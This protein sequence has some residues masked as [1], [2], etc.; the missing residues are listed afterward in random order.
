MIW[1]PARGSA[2]TGSPFR[3]YSDGLLVEPLVPA[4]DP[5]TGA[6]SLRLKLRWIPSVLRWSALTAMALGALG[7]RIERLPSTRIVKGL[8]IVLIVD[9]SRSMLAQ[10]F[11]PNRLGAARRLA[12]TLVLRRVNDR[13]GFITFAGDV[14]LECPVTADRGTLLSTI[15]DVSTSDRSDGTAL[16]EAIASGVSRLMA[17]PTDG[18]VIVVLTD[19][20]S[21]AGGLT[22]EQ[23]AAL[24]A[25]YNV[26][27]Y[28]VGIGASGQV[29]YPTEFGILF[30]ALDLDE[31]VLRNVATTT[32]GQFLRAADS[33]AL[34]TAFG[35]LD[36]LEPAEL[37]LPSQRRDL[38]LSPACA[39]F[40]LTAVLTE[41]F[42]AATFLRA[43]TR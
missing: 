6:P 15:R 28:A 10:D 31:T 8:N 30:L 12:E 20:V 43:V 41:A 21:N 9:A 32:G 11:E 35:T 27:V 22:A 25:A 7:P 16:G 42:A 39:L 34:D 14:L 36:R 40:A 5:D 29:P 1:K 3:H 4:L 18:R 13:F 37:V 17:T 2:P 23:A 24:A 26:R 38:P 33:R 19:G